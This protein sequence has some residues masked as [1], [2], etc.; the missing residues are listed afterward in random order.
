MPAETS[1]SLPK[2]KGPS[3]KPPRPA[4][5]TKSTP[6]PTAS[7]RKSAAAR[8]VCSSSDSSETEVQ[9]TPHSA[10]SDEHEG[11][12]SDAQG[13]SQN[14]PPVI[15]P[16]LLARILHHN[17]GGEGQKLSHEAN[18]LVGKYMDTFVREAIA[19]A[20]YERAEAGGGGVGS[21]F[22]EVRSPRET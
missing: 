6:T 13:V 19:R 3:F 5:R 21:D 15:P 17:V 14:P 20:T 12:S 1:R 2:R 10:S 16:K 8:Q 11:S 18:L 7:R 9:A 22:L 4:S